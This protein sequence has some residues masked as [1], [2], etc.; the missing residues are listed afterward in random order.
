MDASLYTGTGSALTVTNAG[1]FKPD[2]VW[3]KSRSNAYNHGLFDSVRG[4]LKVIQSSSTAAEATESAGTSLTDFNSNGFALGTNGSTVS[5][6]VSAAT[7]V[8]WQWQAGQG[9][10][11]TGTGTGGITSVTQSVNTTAG[12]SIV[13]YTGSGSNGTVTHG[14]GVAPKMI[15]VKTINAVDNWAVYHSSIG[16]TQY[17]Q[18]N[19]T[20]ASA[21]SITLWNDTSPTSTV[22]SVGTNNDV[23]GSART[24]VAY[25]W[26]EIAGFSKFSSYTGN[27]SSDGVF[28]YLGFRPK[29]LMIKRTDAANSWYIY[30]SS[31]NPYNTSKL[32]IFAELSSAEAT[33][34]TSDIDLVSNGFKIRGADS[35]INVGTYIYM[36]FAENPF[37]NANAR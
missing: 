35:G 6:N 9:S 10:T 28:V 37:K 14:L 12:F 8:G 18:L 4:A 21:S 11:T 26:A 24:Y 27:S 13:T 16:A 15:I 23:N 17:L 1:Q 22:F 7:F 30:D 19:T 29:Y 33:S 34:T 25:C 2:F 31:R 36:A 32:V 3:L 20:N 5:T